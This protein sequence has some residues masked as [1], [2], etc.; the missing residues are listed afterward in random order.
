[1]QLRLVACFMALALALPGLAADT[2]WLVR[3]AEQTDPDAEDPALTVAGEAM[4]ARLAEMLGDAGIQAIYSTDFR[5][6]RQTAAP[7]AG[8][9]G[10]EVALYDPGDLKAFAGQLR[11][12]SGPCLVV[13][14]SNTT[15]RL[16]EL[17]G[18]DPAGAI[19]H[20]EFDRLYLIELRDGG[21][22]SM[23]LRIP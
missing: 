15:P 2:I 16:A 17:L 6:T 5:R 7:L 18:G 12:A 19:G 20:M 11:S 4:A 23:L 14:H 9:L 22:E 10:L 13:G 8:K 1:M 21:V 3:H